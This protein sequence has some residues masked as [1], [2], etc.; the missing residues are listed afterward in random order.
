MVMKLYKILFEQSMDNVSWYK[1]DLSEEHEEMERTS[2]ELGIDLQEIVDGYKNGSLEELNNDMWQMMENTDSWDIKDL[3]AARRYAEEY[4]KDIENIIDGFKKGKEL[5]APIVLIKDD[6]VP[7]L[8]A[9]NTRLMV[10]KALKVVPKVV[11]V[12]I[13]GVLYHVA[14]KRNLRSIERNG[15]RVMVPR[16]MEG[17]EAG[18]YLFRSRKDAEE[19]LMNW[20]GDRFDEDEELVLIKVDDRYVDEVS[21]DAAGYEVISKK[22]IPKEGIVGYEVV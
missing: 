8:I 17:E 7:Y 14:K 4:G 16:D 21:S 22:D 10:A 1:P 19:A 13:E 11:I 15:L 20:L 6:K 2:K 18:V 3:E 5:P 12:R 9:G